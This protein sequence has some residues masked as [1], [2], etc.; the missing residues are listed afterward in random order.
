MLPLLARRLA[1][2]ARAL[3]SLRAQT[4]VDFVLCVGAVAEHFPHEAAGVAFV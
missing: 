2:Q 1:I 4:H 3:Q